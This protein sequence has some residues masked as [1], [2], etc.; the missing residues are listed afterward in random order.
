M[1]GDE[2]EQPQERRQPLRAG[3]AGAASEPGAPDGSAP[4]GS[5]ARAG[6]VG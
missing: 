2:G 6:R 4:Y 1:I 5:C 3:P